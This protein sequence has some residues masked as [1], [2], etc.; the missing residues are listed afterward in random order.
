MYQRISSRKWKLC[1]GT[2]RIYD[3]AIS[4]A[5][6]PFRLILRKHF[7]TRINVLPDIQVYIVNI[8][9]ES[10]HDS[11]AGCLVFEDSLKFLEKQSPL[12]KNRMS[13]LFSSIVIIDTAVESSSYFSPDRCC[14]LNPWKITHY[15]KNPTAVSVLIAGSLVHALSTAMLLNGRYGY[16]GVRRHRLLSLKAQVRFLQKAISEES[17]LDV[18]A[19]ISV[20]N[21]EIDKLKYGNLHFTRQPTIGREM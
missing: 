16:L 13:G 14:F 8:I 3:K 2:L 10:E 9:V 21:K 20:F 12:W 17:N 11:Q 18:L 19:M 4:S 6:M 7:C 5:N 15:V 1:A